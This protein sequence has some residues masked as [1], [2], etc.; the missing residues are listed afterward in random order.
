MDGLDR[1]V[2]NV[3]IRRLFAA[4]L[5]LH[6]ALAKV[7]DRRVRLLVCDALDEMDSAIRHIQR[8]AFETGLVPGSTIDEEA[9]DRDEVAKE[10]RR[11]PAP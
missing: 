10:V 4:G 3:T 1:E 8:A 6:K 5:D 11:G 9:R 2:L 7:N